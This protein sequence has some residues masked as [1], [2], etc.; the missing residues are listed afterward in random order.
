[1]TKNYDLGNAYELSYNSRG[2]TSNG[3]CDW[4]LAK[5]GLPKFYKA[6]EGDDTPNKIVIV[7]YEIK[8]KLHPWVHAGKRKI[9]DLAYVLDVKVHQKVGPGEVS[10]LCPSNYG[11]SCPLCEAEKSWEGRG[12]DDQNPFKAKRRV[13]YNVLD[14]SDPEDG[15]KVFDV[16]HYYFE[17][18]LISAAARKGADGRPVPFANVKDGKT[19]KFFGVKKT[20]GKFPS[21]EFKDFEFVDRKVDIVD[22]VEK[23]I[24]FDELLTLHTY[25]EIMMI[26]T[27]TDE[28]DSNAGSE[29]DE[30]SEDVADERKPDTD[31][32]DAALE[33]R[34][35]AKEAAKAEGGD[36]CPSGHEFGVDWGDYPECKRDT[37]A[38]YRKCGSTDVKR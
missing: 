6:K 21:I 35:K 33:A 37:C 12:K 20:T 25:D 13:Y 17:K 7:P 14:M 23:A 32:E 38:L 36:A 26:M 1:M 11:K 19:I 8:S 15:L 16:S 10:V 27:G 30:S 24:S 28:E 22:Y 29:P 34:R 9:G 2:G 3:A 18:E 4:S 5:G 31:D